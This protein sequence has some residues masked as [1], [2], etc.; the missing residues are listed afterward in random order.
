MARTVPPTAGAGLGQL[1]FVPGWTVFIAS[2]SSVKCLALIAVPAGNKSPGV[3]SVKILENVA[4][5][6]FAASTVTTH[7]VAVPPQAPPHCLN[8]AAAP[9]VAV[10][11]RGV[12]LM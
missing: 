12:P 6:D 4:V 8:V 11:R 7:V 9:G 10:S 5:T 1:R 3:A 2:R